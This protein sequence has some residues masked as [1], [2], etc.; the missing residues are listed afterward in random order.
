M[1]FEVRDLAAGRRG[2]AIVRGLGFALEPGERVA[3]VG[4]SGVG[5]TTVLRA[6]A[7]LDDPLAGELRLDG[8]A[9]EELGL[10][11]WRRRVALVPQRAVLFGGTVEAELAR[12]FTYASATGSFDRARARALLARVGLDAAWQRPAQELSEGERQRV[13]LVR[14]LLID[15]DVLLLDEPTSALDPESTALVEAVLVASGAAL[16]LVTHSAAQR[17]RLGARE[18]PLEPLR[19]AEAERA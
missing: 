7:L 13:V 14:S 15:P 1:A 5:K 4:P 9:P 6:L 8:R 12:P 18:I 19:A 17:E 10:P 16:V 11:R 2:R 3:L